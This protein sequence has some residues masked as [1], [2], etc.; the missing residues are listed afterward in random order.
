[1]LSSP[2]HLLC[3]YPWVQMIWKWTELGSHGLYV[4]FPPSQ[5][6]Q[7]LTLVSCTPDLLSSIRDTK[8]NE[9]DDSLEQEAPR[10]EAGPAPHKPTSAR[11]YSSI[12]DL[13]NSSLL[14]CSR[15][16]LSKPVSG[17]KE[18]KSTSAVNTVTSTVVGGAVCLP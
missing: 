17:I 14:S 12:T 16:E 11:P 2:P 6:L 9:T 18:A 7:P 5:Y 1:M 8:K 3:T 10:E 4:C 15:P 13:R